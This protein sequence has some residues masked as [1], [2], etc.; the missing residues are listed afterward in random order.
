MAKHDKRLLGQT[1]TLQERGVDF[2][3]LRWERLAHENH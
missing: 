3:R 2:N 1:N